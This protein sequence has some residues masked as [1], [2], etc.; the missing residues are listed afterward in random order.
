MRITFLV[1]TCCFFS[2]NLFAI[3]PKKEYVGTPEDYDIDFQEFCVVNNN[4]ELTGWIS[5]SPKNTN[6]AIIL[7]YGDYGNMSYFL[8][9][10]K[11]YTNLGFDVI[12]FD[13]RG[14]G[15]SSE[16]QIKPD[17]LFYHQFADD[18][19]TVFKY[20]K[21]TIGYS[22]LGVVSLSMGTIITVLAIKNVN[23]DFI[24]AEGC[25]FNHN[26]IIL[27][28]QKLKNKNLLIP[29]ENFSLQDLWARV[30]TRL[31]IFS[32][33]EDQITTLSDAQKIVE[34]KIQHRELVEYAGQ[35]LGILNTKITENVYRKSLIS[36]LKQDE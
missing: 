13:Y 32:A 22:K 29:G 20:S 14:F 31:I 4:V 27:R 36:F 28:L 24:V 11:F 26:D 19:V 7:T 2:F 16:F 9:Y 23:F 17:I 25:V 5:K 15:K 33:S 1:I 3:D 30:D 8:P 12:S 18:L 6:G 10:I 34:Q 21:N 35:H